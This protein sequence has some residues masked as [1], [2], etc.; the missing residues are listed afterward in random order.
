MKPNP[1][2]HRANRGPREGVRTAG[3]E[4]RGVRQ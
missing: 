3:R 1:S 4:V 2:F